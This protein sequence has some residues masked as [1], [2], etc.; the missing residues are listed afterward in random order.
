MQ[1]FT[2]QI[3]IGGLVFIGISVAIF[4]AIPQLAV[5]A[6]KERESLMG[7]QLQ[8][9]IDEVYAKQK[10]AVNGEKT[11][12]DTLYRYTELLQI[13]A[14]KLASTYFVKS[15]RNSEEDRLVGKS[16]SERWQ[17]ILMLKKTQNQLARLNFSVSPVVLTSPLHIILSKSDTGAWQLVSIK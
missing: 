7:Q 5:R 13:N 2:K 1:T 10:D 6:S 3:F 15:A 4:F 9:T 17:Y 8:K 11:P 12:Y 16:Q 14:D